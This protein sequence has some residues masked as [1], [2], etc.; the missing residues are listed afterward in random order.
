MISLKYS[1]LVASYG[2][3]CL[4]VVNM[5]VT[6]TQHHNITLLVFSRCI[7]NLQI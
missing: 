5:A 1:S 7:F 2:T 3:E 6:L 4:A